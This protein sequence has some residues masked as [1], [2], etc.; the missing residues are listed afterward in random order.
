[1]ELVLRITIVLAIVGAR[2]WRSS[3]LRELL[4]VGLL[5]LGLLLIVDN[6][7]EIRRRSR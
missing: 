7:G 5:A 6:L 1:M 3:I 4:L 2:S